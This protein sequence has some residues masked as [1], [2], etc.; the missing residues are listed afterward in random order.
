MQSNS[1]CARPEPVSFMFHAQLDNQR[2]CRTRRWDEPQERTVSLRC[3]NFSI[4]IFVRRL[5]RGQNRTRLGLQWYA[6]EAAL[7]SG[8]QCQTRQAV[9][10]GVR[11]SVK[12]PNAQANI[13]QSHTPQLRSSHCHTGP[14]LFCL[15]DAAACTQK[16]TP[17]GTRTRN[18]QIIT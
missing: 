8:C 18:P 11:H 15:V 7:A 16:S 17:A 9:H 2:S 5:C 14:P 6:C 12:V 10:D 1:R 4:L 13:A 3:P